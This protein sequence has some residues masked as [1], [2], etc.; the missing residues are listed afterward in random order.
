MNTKVPK[1]RLLIII[2][3]FGSFNNFLSE[4]C[5]QLVNNIFFEIVVVCSK[6]KVIEIEDKFDFQAL[7][8]K[9]YFVNIPRGLNVFK[10]IRASRKINSII[11]FEKPDII[12]A[13]FTTGIF[14]TLLLKKPSTKIWGTFHGLG[15]VTSKGLRKLMFIIVEFF[16]FSRLNKIIVLNQEDYQS[17]PNIYRHKLSKLKS[18]GLGCNIEIFNSCNFD[19]ESKA[20]LRSQLNI[21]NHFVLAF[22]GRFVNFKGFDIAAR[23]FIKLEQKYPDR[24]KFLLIGG[25][26][27]IHPT[28]LNEDEE[29]AFFNHRDVVNVGF[30]NEVPKYLSIVNV[31][32]FP[33]KK[34]G[35]PISITEALAMGIPIIASN[36]RGNHDLV[37]DLFNGILIDNQ[38]DNNV[39]IDSF[40][41]AV[42]SLF[43]DRLLYEFF[44][45]NAMSCR[46]LLSR[47]NFIDDQIE[48]YSSHK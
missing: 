9:F 23:T 29:K 14:T 28:G 35:V 45:K 42:E 24:L 7:G 11:S 44:K 20:N 43:T 38:N 37:T 2:T 25:L 31:F 10:Q 1:N 6:D 12:H 22:T 33:S 27:V 32:I 4:L 34:E 5:V 47:Q 48:L 46:E 21:N 40:F 19:L 8:I 17:V 18:L 15:F 26:D 13:H 36:S 30:T 41:E 39:E 3:D 16:C